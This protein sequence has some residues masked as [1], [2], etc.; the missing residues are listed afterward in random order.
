MPETLPKLE[1]L[2]AAGVLGLLVLIGGLLLERACR[3]RDDDADP[4]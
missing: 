1:D 2:L 3:V 4:E